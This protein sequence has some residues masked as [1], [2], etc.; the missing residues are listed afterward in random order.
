MT[1]REQLETLEQ[2]HQD[3][4]KQLQR[5]ERRGHLTPTEQR[6]AKELKKLKLRRKDAIAVLRRSVR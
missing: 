6:K 5:L 4:D 2:E 1:K 3:L